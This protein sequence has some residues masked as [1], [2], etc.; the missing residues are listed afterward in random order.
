MAPPE[1]I[2]RFYSPVESVNESEEDEV[3]FSVI[4]YKAAVMIT[5]FSIVCFPNDIPLSALYVLAVVFL[6]CKSVA[7]R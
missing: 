3:S 4:S 2:R 6:Y 5:H 1:S 7:I